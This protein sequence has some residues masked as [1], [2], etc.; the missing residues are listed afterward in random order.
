M[1]RMRL[2]LVFVGLLLTPLWSL[3][4]RALDIQEVASPSGI[5]AWLIQD[6]TAPVISL[7]FAFEG[8][9][10]LDP[11]GKDG[12]SRMMAALLDEGAGPYDSAAF[13]AEVEAVAARLSFSADAD[14]VTGSL[15]TL[16][17]KRERAFEL[18]RLAI[19]E[20]RFAEADVERIRSQMLSNLRSSATSPNWIAGRTLTETLFQKHPYARPSDGSFDTV[21]NIKIEDLRAVHKRVFVRGGLTVAVVGD[22]TPEELARLLDRAFDSVP[23]GAPQ[24]RV[25]E[26]NGPPPGRTIVLERDFPQSVVMLARQGLKRDDPDWFPAFL[27]NYIL[28]G[29]GFNSRLTE[30]IREKRGLAYGV[31]T[32]LQAYAA[33]GIYIGSVATANARVGQSIDLIKQEMVRLAEGGVTAQELAN[34]KTYVAGSFALNFSS[35]GAIASI[36]LTVQLDKL[37]RDYFDRRNALIEQVTQEDIKRVAKR[38]L[39]PKDFVVVVVGQPAGVKSSE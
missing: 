21:P 31:S 36:L 14:Y 13:Q 37:G 24:Q 23:A 16:S 2:L 29:G 38:L 18:L 7:S 27:M 17:D 33:G 15:R 34:A 4:A 20:P 25:A 1:S 32:A 22:I 8:G 35:S 10:A 11:A 39:D 5:K 30:E 3:P 12:A 9:A 19:S 26:W 6:S 28:G